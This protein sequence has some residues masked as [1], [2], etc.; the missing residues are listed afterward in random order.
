MSDRF[1]DPRY[2]MESATLVA[3][4]GIMALAMNYVIT[5]GHIDLSVS[6]N[7]VLCACLTA[8]MLQAGVPPIVALPLCL[9]LGTL[10]GVF[11][12]VLI[13]K[14]NTP[15]FLVTV[16]TMAVYRG[17][18]QAY[19]GPNSVKFPEN[20]TGIDTQT[21]IGLTVPLLILVVLAV[22]SGLVFSNT[23]FGRWVTAVGSNSRAALYSAV[24]VHKVTISVFAIAGFASGLAALLL[25]SRLGVVRHD[26][27]PGSELDVITI[28][29]VG[30]TAIRGGDVNVLGTVLAFV[31]LA[32]MRTAMG[33]A[34]YPAE[35]QL[36]AIGILLIFAVI[37]NRLSFKTN[38][39]RFL[40]KSGSIQ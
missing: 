37:I 1:L 39:L 38:P 16:G 21:F 8:K 28:V 31:T 15:S 23:V 33:V 25:S 7:M 29:V 6:A 35:N 34:N 2:L 12:G 18:A 13:T 40:K 32:F 19:L 5:A 22:I 24:P 9:V 27:L 20:L 17:I 4:I 3:E 30:G 36:I 11:N 14:L 10:L 26:L